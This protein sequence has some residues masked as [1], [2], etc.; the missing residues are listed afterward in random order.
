MSL[1]YQKALWREIGIWKR[2][3]HE[4]IVPLLGTTTHYSPVSFVSPWMP[5]GTLNSYLKVKRSLAEKYS[6]LY[7]VADGLHYL[8]SES[9][10]H[11]DLTSSNVLINQGGQACLT[12]FGLSSM[13][14][15]GEKF[16]YLHLN[17]KRP[18]A[19][20][21]AAPELIEC[22]SSVNEDEKRY[23][24]STSSDIYSYGCI[25][26]EVSMSPPSKLKQTTLRLLGSFR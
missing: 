25:M 4:C 1:N 13:M 24:P 16:E 5:D 23:M 7:D 22:T 18:G 26:Y 6:L 11:G 8:H 21:W 10:V 12:D 3:R 20:P 17:E 9:V 2:M 19:V 15:I 14:K